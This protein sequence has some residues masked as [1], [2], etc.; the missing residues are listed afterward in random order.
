MI[1]EPHSFQAHEIYMSLIDKAIMGYKLIILQSAS[2][3]DNLELFFGDYYEE[4]DLYRERIRD[5][6]AAHEAMTK[7]RDLILE[8][9]K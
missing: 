4:L 6:R 9:L 7:L 1:E 8:K 2:S 3:I 5:A